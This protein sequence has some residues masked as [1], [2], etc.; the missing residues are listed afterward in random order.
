MLVNEALNKKRAAEEGEEEEP[1]SCWQSRIQSMASYNHRIFLMSKTMVGNNK[2]N[3]MD[4][5]WYILFC[6]RQKFYYHSDRGECRLKFKRMKFS[7]AL[8]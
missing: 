7:I 2:S 4:H 5:S 3:A 1:S 8:F 6:S